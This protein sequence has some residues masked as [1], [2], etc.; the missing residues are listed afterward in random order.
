VERT[1]SYARLL[2]HHRG[3]SSGLASWAS[4]LWTL[5][6]EHRGL[7]GSLGWIGLALSVLASAVARGRAID[8]FGLRR[9]GLASLVGVAAGDAALWLFGPLLLAITARG[10][11]VHAVFRVWLIALFFLTPFY[12]P[13]PRLLLPLAAAGWI[14]FAAMLATSFGRERSTVHSEPAVRMWPAIIAAC[15]A[16]V[17]ILP[18]ARSLRSGADEA[19]GDRPT[20][21]A[22]CEMVA[23]SLPA[24]VPTLCFVRPPVLFYVAAQ[25]PV[26]LMN[27]DS[28]IDELI[29]GVPS[30]RANLLIDRALVRDTPQL[31]QRLAAAGARLRQRASVAYWPGLRVA[32]DDFGPDALRPESLPQMHATYEL[33]VIAIEP[34]SE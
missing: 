1:H 12:K 25:R 17:A 11:P 22:A 13:Y 28:D 2:E 15:L 30:G 29:D 5:F 6:L 23:E 8:V 32:L 34:A 10:W 26:R 14:V 16:I 18:H 19:A 21:Q 7:N 27:P 33:I 24:E 20:L 9:V 31:G 4:N 3:Y